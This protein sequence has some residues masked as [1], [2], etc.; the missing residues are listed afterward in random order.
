MNFPTTIKIKIVKKNVN[1]YLNRIEI[2]L[3]SLLFN[4]VKKKLIKLKKIN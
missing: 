4:V 1:K 2:N 3:K